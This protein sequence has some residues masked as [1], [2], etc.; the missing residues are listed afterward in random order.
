MAPQPNP[1]PVENTIEVP[2]PVE[3]GND[4]PKQKLGDR[5]RGTLVVCS[6]NLI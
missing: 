3:E 1:I 2:L 6:I 4:E 5:V